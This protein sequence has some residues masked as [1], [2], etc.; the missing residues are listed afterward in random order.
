MDSVMCIITSQVPIRIKKILTGHEVTNDDSR[1]K[2][3][4]M[5]TEK[6]MRQAMQ[7]R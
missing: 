7:K 3:E 5:V 1:D 2:D 6:K 4:V